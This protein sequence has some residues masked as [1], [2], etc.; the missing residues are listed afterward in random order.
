MSKVTMHF[1]VR[2][3]SFEIGCGF[4]ELFTDLQDIT[5]SFLQDITVL[6]AAR[7]KCLIIDT[8]K[9]NNPYHNNID[10]VY[11]YLFHNLE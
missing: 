6:L 7:S 1:R 5:C 11:G 3:W 4:F 10:K 9:L 2:H 8:N